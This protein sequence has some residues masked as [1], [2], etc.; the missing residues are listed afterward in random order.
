MNTVA[1][2]GSPESIEE[3][4]RGRRAAGWVTRNRVLLALLAL[5]LIKS[6]L[7]SVIIPPWRASDEPHHFG[8]IQHLSREHSFP[9][10]GESFLYPDLYTSLNRTNFSGIA[11]AESTSFDPY[12]REPNL[13]AGHPPFYYLLLLPAYRASAGASVETQLYLTRIW[14][15]GIFVLL[16][17]AA[18]RLMGLVFPA[19]P[20]MRIGVPLLLIFHPQL[21]FISGAILNDGLTATLFTLL[22]IE[23][24]LLVRGDYRW[25]RAIFAGVILGLGMLT[26]SSFVFAWPIVLGVL[27]VLLIRRS[28]SRRRLLWLAM[29]IAAI[30]VLVCFWYYLRNYLSY[31]S[32]QPIGKGWS[33]GQDSWLGL[34]FETRFATDLL[35]NFLGNFN[36][37]SIPLPEQAIVLFKGLVAIAALGTAASLVIGWRRRGWRLAEGWVVALLAAVLLVYL[38]ATAWFEYKWGNTQG[39]YIFPAV[40]PFWSLFLIGLTGWLPPAWRPRAAAVVV[41]VAAVFGIWAAV[42][43][44]LPRVT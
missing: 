3:A 36:W 6:V 8:Y 19:A 34:W 18:W 13:A 40:V 30:G 41:T 2:N 16:I 24:V 12:M 28:G 5:A 23:L 37:Q 32:F 38:L 17:A 25:R 39:R 29:A 9:I 31:G 21:G 20:W 4:G 33:Y 15:A 22:M 44:Y 35:G 42:F 10:S 43:E 11:G 14:G 7:W 26:K 1:V 27:A